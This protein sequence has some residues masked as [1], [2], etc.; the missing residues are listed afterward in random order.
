MTLTHSSRLTL[1][2]LVALHLGACGSSATPTQ[3]T[4]TVGAAGATLHVGRSTL[5][6]PAGALSAPTSITVR[7]AEPRH[8]GRAARVELEPHGLA[9][10]TPAQL[11]VEVSD[12]NVK[13]KLHADD[14][15]LL[16]VEVEDRQHGRFKTSVGQLGD[17]EVELEHGLA[18]SP[19]CGT[20]EA[21]DDGVCMPH[22]S[23]GV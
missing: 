23:G 3:R 12:D 9:L 20:S 19:A 6:I 5:A 4:S 8:A 1:G 10:G 15:G 18:C 22:R 21:C 7:E 14:D 11:V 13:V 2:A 17:V 16:P